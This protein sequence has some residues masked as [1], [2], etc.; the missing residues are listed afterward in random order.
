MGNIRAM[1]TKKLLST[2]IIALAIIAVL[3]FVYSIN[4]PE[5]SYQCWD[6]SVVSDPSLCPVNPWS[7]EGIS[8]TAEGIID[9][10][11]TA[12]CQPHQIFGV[13]VDLC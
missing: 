11:G 9:S 12:I 1:K 6:N 8:N 5:P 4:I 10:I 3:L 2:A 7:W 13:V